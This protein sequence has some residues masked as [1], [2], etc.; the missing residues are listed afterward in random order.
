MA[1]MEVRAAGTAIFMTRKKDGSECHPLSTNN[2]CFS[3]KIMGHF[4]F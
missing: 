2:T 1:G 3:S 4:H